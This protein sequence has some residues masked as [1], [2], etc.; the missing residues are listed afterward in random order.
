MEN[1]AA[2]LSNFLE[3]DLYLIEEPSS[4]YK[5]NTD[6]I[7]AVVNLHEPEI[8]YSGNNSS[9]VMILV[10]EEVNEKDLLLLSK[11]LGAVKLDLENVA[12]VKADKEFYEN[13]SALTK[14]DAQ[15]LISFGVT[16]TEIQQLDIQSKYA[17][18]TLEDR[19]VIIADTLS[20]LHQNQE[21]KKQLW[22]TLKEVFQ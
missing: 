15:I 6:D 19:I 17:P 7:E 18:T 14:F 13:L 8:S 5:I 20:E 16:C 3:E 1:K 21:L 12:L 22:S 10:N 4:S 9:E 11:I 2:F